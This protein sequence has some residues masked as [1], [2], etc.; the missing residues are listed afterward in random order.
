MEEEHRLVEFETRSGESV[1]VGDVTVT[2]QSSAFT[3]RWPGGG[4]V[5]NRPVAVLVEGPGGEERIPI[6]DVT[7]LAQVLLLGLGVLFGLVAFILAASQ[8][9][10]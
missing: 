7:L 10:K 1:T 6:V 9:R 8:R 4:F 3:L 2:P 5:W